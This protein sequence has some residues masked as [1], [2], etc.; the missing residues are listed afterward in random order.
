[1]AAKKRKI[2]P[3]TFY[4]TAMGAEPVRKWLKALS[5][6]DQRIVGTDVATVEFGWPVGMPTCRPLNS[7]RGL[8][9]VR[10]SLTRN[11]IARVLFFVYQ[12]QMVLLH[13]FSK[14]TQQTPEQ[15]LDLAVKRQKEVESGKT[16]K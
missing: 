12:G 10:S 8:W 3:A 15:D 6:E 9:E 5:R 2:L 16:A 13:A 7:R 14:K 4:R 1:M 11:R